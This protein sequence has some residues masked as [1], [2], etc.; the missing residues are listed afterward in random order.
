MMKFVNV[1]VAVQSVEVVNVDVAVHSL[2]FVENGHIESSQPFS[3][4]GDDGN[5]IF[6]ACFELI[7]GHHDITVTVTQFICS[8]QHLPV[9]SCSLPLRPLSPPY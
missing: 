2:Q 5:G 6:F 7:P 9:A 3:L 4:C 8:L 1:D